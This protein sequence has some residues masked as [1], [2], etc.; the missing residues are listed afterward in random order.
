MEPEAGEST[1]LVGEETSEVL[2]LRLPRK[3]ASLIKTICGYLLIVTAGILFTVANV[4]QKIVAP[5]LVFWHLLVYRA[6]VQIA[7]TYAELKWRGVS[8]LG[9]REHRWRIVTQGLL[10]GFLLLCLFIAIKHVPLGSASAIFFCTPVFTFVFAVTMLKERLGAYRVLISALMIG[11]VLLITRP[12][13]IFPPDFVPSHHD[14]NGTQQHQGQGDESEAFSTMGYMCA[15]AVPLFSAIV[16]IMCRQLKEVRPSV[17]MLWFGVGA[18]IVSV[19]GT[20]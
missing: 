12:P 17:L 16:S 3:K 6:F 8:P 4:I 20:G 10:G 11:G 14:G 9:P 2:C 15:I 7:V 19:G 5:E 1:P 13:F 18:L